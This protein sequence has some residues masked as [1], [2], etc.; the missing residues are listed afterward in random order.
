MEETEMEETEQHGRNR[1][2]VLLY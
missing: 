2:T 1:A